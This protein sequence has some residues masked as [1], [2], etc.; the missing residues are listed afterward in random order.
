[1]HVR[2]LIY[3]VVNCTFFVFTG[4]SLKIFVMMIC[5]GNESN[6]F[7]LFGKAEET[8][9]QNYTQVYYIRSKKHRGLF[10]HNPFSFL[11][12]IKELS[13]P[14]FKCCC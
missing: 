7:P 11:V 4:Q 8:I 13:N 5:A 1:M 6:F 12:I 2:L 14:L 10:S 3:Q 9:W